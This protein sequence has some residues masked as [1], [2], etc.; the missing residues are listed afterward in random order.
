[1]RISN[2][3]YHGGTE[4]VESAEVD[5]GE[6]VVQA[7]I[8]HARRRLLTNWASHVLKLPARHEQVREFHGR[9]LRLTTEPPLPVSIDGEILAH[10]PVVAKI[11]A[12]VI[13][14]MAPI[15]P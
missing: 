7:V 9:S 3:P 12:G 5:S 1:M 15:T 6:I 11:A 4:I 13:E 14:V 8:G 10:T 2:G